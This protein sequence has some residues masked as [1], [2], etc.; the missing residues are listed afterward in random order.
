MKVQTN[1]LR[2]TDSEVDAVSLAPKWLVMLKRFSPVQIY[3]WLSS[4]VR[5][6]IAI[7]EV[8][9]TSPVLS[10]TTEFLNKILFLFSCST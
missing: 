2:C 1:L 3:I 6:R 5:F 8:T 4:M 9:V 7:V 10:D